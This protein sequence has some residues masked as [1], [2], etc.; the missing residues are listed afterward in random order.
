MNLCGANTSSGIISMACLNFPSDI[1]YKPENMY[2][3]GII[4]GLKQPS[5]KHLNHYIQPLIDDMVDLWEC[6]HKL[7]KMACYP[8]GQLTHSAVTLI[9]CSHFHCS[10]CNCFHKTTYVRVDFEHW[11]L[12]DKDKPWEFAEQWRDAAMTSECVR[13]FK[14]HGVH[15]SELWHLP[16]W[17]PSCQLVIDPMHCVLEGLVQ[18]HTHNILS[19]TTVQ[20]AFRDDVNQGNDPGLCYIYTPCFAAA[21]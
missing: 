4:P 17:D 21:F 12:W 6:S 19:L 20:C 15:Y 3:A 2:L 1:R 5:L 7:S 18:H 14:N 11:E 8:T 10:T 13:L 16:Y 9:V